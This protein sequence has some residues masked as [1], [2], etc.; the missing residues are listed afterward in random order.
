MFADIRKKFFAALVGSLMFFGTPNCSAGG[1]GV[2]M[3]T[4]GILS[5]LGG[6]V[7]TF[8]TIAAKLGAFTGKVMKAKKSNS[9]TS[10]FA[11][12]CGHLFCFSPGAIGLGAGV[13]LIAAGTQH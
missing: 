1:A 11:K 5:T 9:E 13:G 2:A 12:I 3:I 4:G 7:L 6:G 8:N 10:I